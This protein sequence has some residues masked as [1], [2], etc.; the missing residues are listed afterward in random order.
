MLDALHPMLRKIIDIAKHIRD[1]D[2]KRHDLRGCSI[3]DTRSDFESM[4][5]QGEELFCVTE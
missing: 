3:F 2:E 1:C 5:L 4:V